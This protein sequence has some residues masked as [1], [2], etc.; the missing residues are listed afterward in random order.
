MPLALLQLEYAMTGFLTAEEDKNKISKSISSI[1]VT[2]VLTAFLVSLL[3]FIL[4]E[5]LA[6]AVFGDA[7]ATSA[8]FGS[9]PSLFLCL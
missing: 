5:P 7:G 1:F 2:V 6:T 4:A 8:F 3:I 9:H